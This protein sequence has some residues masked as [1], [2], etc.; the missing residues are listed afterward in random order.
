M[1]DQVKF[2]VEKLNREPFKKT[3][4]FINFDNLQGNNLLQLLNDVFAEIDPKVSTWYKWLKWWQ[5]SVFLRKFQFILG[6]LAKNGYSWRRTRTDGD[7]NVQSAK[8]S[9]IQA[10]RWQRVI[11]EKILNQNYAYINFN[12]Y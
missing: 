12:I 3:L 11:K 1:N 10:A 9:Q 4:N 2:I 8:S 5:S 7:K 6:K